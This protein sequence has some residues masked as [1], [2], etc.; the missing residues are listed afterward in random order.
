[1][2]PLISFVVFL[3]L[4]KLY[5]RIFDSEP[6]PYTAYSMDLSLMPDGLFNF[7]F[8]VLGLM[9]PMFFVLALE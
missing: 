4:R 1:M 9:V 3:L 6:S 7:F 2:I 8:L 5:L